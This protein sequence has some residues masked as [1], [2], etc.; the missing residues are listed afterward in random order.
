MAKKDVERLVGR[1]LLDAEF[2]EKLFADPEAT[3]QEAGFDLTEKEIAQL[4]RVDKE[5]AEALA[6]E[7]GATPEDAWK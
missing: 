3:I 5:K 1:A 4:K 7:L 6:A 2:R